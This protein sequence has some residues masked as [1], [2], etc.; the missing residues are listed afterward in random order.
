MPP[1]PRLLALLAT[2]LLT[3][4]LL[5]LPV[6][7]GVHE[8]PA[9]HA[10]TVLVHA[11]PNWVTTLH[12]RPNDPLLDQQWSLERIG[13]TDGDGSARR[14]A[15]GPRSRSSTGVTGSSPGVR[16]QGDPLPELGGSRG[17]LDA[18]LRSR[19]LS[20]EA[21]R[22]AIRQG[23]AVTGEGLRRISVPASLERAA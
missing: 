21:T 7:G 15:R 23:A 19:G 9:H 2:I 13:A 1:H 16:R 18:A 5:G 17:R 6:A 14:S 12:A 22:P 20:A 11:E 8:V 4:A 10:A 3:V